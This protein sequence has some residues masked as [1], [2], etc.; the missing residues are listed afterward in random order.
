MSDQ[1]ITAVLTAPEALKL[2]ELLGRV[3]F[4][5]VRYG[6]FADDA[7]VLYLK[8]DAALHWQLGGVPALIMVEPWKPGQ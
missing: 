2:R 7:A 4:D 3:R 6:R 8:L 5:Q 1:P